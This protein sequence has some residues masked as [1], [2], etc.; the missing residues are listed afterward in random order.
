MSATIALKIK[1]SGHKYF[2]INFLN[3]YSP[4]TYSSWVFKK[5]LMTAL[6]LSWRDSK[7]SP[8]FQHITKPALKLLLECNLVVFY[9]KAPAFVELI[10]PGNG[11]IKVKITIIWTQFYYYLVLLLCKRAKNLEIKFDCS[12]PPISLSLMVS[13]LEIW[14]RI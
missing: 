10:L 2:G 8:L 1:F 13:E 3:M 9:Y 5:S 12:L 14:K 4:L 7:S 11:E 6:R